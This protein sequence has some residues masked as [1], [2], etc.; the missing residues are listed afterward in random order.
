MFCDESQSSCEKGCVNRKCTF[1]SLSDEY[2]CQEFLKTYI[3]EVVG[4]VFGVVVGLIVIAILVVKY[5][6]VRDSRYGFSKVIKDEPDFEFMKEDYQ[7]QK[8]VLLPDTLYQVPVEL[9]QKDK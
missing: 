7:T 2:C 8:Q 4:I 3:W 9:G 6:Q 1:Y 5:K